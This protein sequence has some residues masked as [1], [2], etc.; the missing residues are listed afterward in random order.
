[1]DQANNRP[2]GETLRFPLGPSDTENCAESEASTLI[3]ALL[4]GEELT[5][6]EL[7]QLD[8]KLS[9]SEEAREEYINA[10]SMHSGLMNIFGSGPSIDWPQSLN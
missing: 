10:V 9:N 1:M 5:E 4:N 8:E 3:W 7:K 2:D 6:E